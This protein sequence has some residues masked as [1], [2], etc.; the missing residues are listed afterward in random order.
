[1]LL[2]AWKKSS[3]PPTCSLQDR[4][5]T[6][7]ASCPG[8]SCWRRANRS[9][10][11]RF[12]STIPSGALHQDLKPGDRFFWYTTTGRM[13]WNYLLSGLLVGATILVYDGSTAYPDMNQLW[14]FAEASGMNL[15][16]ISAAYI[17]AC[18]K[19]G[20]EPGRNFNLSRLKNLSSTGSPLLPEGF[21]WTAAARVEDS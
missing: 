14:R 18:M 6:S 12:P 20:I 2:P 16:G 15:F 21:R 7:P 10:A 3:S 13:M 19:A 4:D 8:R 1:M 17:A 9:V 11:R 5:P